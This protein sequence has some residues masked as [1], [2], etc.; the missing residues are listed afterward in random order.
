MDKIKVANW[1]DF[2]IGDK[3]EHTKTITDEDIQIFAKLSGDFNPIH[4]NEEYAKTTMFR[5][6]IAHG[7]IS[8]SLISA[9]LGMHLPGPG[10]VY[11]SQEVKFRNPVFIGDKLTAKGEVV[12]KFTKK[13][14]KLKF[15]KIQTNVYK[16][17]EE[18]V[19]EGSAL[20][21]IQ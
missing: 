17:E 18:L 11:M 12:E 9:V 16:Q 6:R 4:V 1:D 5:Q 21:I 13:E 8:V 20:V 3:A 15:L 14:G 7:M 2:N 10:A 19:T